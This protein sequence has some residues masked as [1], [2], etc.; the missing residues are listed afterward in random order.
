LSLE[1]GA[2]AGIFLGGGEGAE[3]DIKSQRY[4]EEKNRSLAALG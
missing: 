4:M 2:R 1:V 3:A